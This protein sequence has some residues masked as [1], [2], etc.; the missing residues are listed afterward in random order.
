MRRLPAATTIAAMARL[1]PG[2]VPPEALA[3]FVDEHFDR[4]L[5]RADDRDGLLP[6]SELIPL[7]LRLLDQIARAEYDED[8]ALLIDA[9]QDALLGRAERGEL[10]AT[11]RFDW[12]VWFRRLRA[13]ALLGFGS[14]PRGMVY[15]GFPGPSYRPGH[16]WLDEG[17]VAAR[18][19]RRRGYLWL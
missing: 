4:Q 1:L 2:A 15:M 16:V 3:V 9:E 6:R 18:V 11:E 5:G 7:G 14:D 8:F 13:L 17:E 12:T 19:A 10:A